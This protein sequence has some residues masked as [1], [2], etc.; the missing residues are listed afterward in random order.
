MINT[1]LELQKAIARLFST[2]DGKLILKAWEDNFILS[3]PHYQGITQIDL[4]Y[5][6]GKG[7]FVRAIK[8][9]VNNS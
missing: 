7:D 2:E 6:S 8:L 9:I 5:N 3:S 1:E 4:A